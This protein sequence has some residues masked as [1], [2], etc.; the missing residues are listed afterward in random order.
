MW[1]CFLFGAG[2]ARIPFRGFSRLSREKSAS[3]QIAKTP[4][5]TRGACSAFHPQ[6]L[7]DFHRLPPPQSVR[8]RVHLWTKVR[9]RSPRTR[10]PC[11]RA[12]DWTHAKTEKGR[13]TGSLRYN[14]RDTEITEAKCGIFLFRDGSAWIPFRGF[15]R[16]SREKSASRQIAKTPRETRGACSAFHPQI[17]RDFHRLPPPQSVRIRVHLWTK[18]RKRSSRTLSPCAACLRGE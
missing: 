7:R 8:I 15:S 5:E 4:R 13:K 17:L 14:H 3:R 2:S 18:A 1:G 12:T 9:K 10:S 11:L 6:I 16:L